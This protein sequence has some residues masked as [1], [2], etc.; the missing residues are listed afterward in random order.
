MG[1]G[2]IARN[3][4]VLLFP[5]VFSIGLDNS[6]IFIKFEIFFC[7][8]LEFGR[9]QNLSFWNGSKRGIQKFII[10]QNFK[11]LQNSSPNYKIIDQSNLKTYA[12][13]KITVR[14]ELKFPF[15]KVENFL[16][17]FVCF[18]RSV[19]NVSKTKPKTPSFNDSQEEDVLKTLWKNGENASYQHILL[20]PKRF[21]SFETV[22]F[23][24]KDKPVNIIRFIF[25]R[26]LEN[27]RAWNKE[28]KLQKKP[29]NSSFQ[30]KKTTYT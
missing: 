3:E 6:A 18:F 27:L 23:G 4:Q 16:G 17:G 28:E 21:L 20:F 12:N 1:K 9:V 7:K 26:S 30:K 29:A 19:S 8:L 10:T 15:R 24:D 22:K 5:T 14:R 2:E 13:D 11:T 25:I